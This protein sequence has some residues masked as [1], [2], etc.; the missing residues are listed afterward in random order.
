[1]M[2]RDFQQ[3][4]LFQ[5]AK[6]YFKNLMNYSLTKSFSFIKTWDSLSSEFA[7]EAV[8][9]PSLYRF[10]RARILNDPDFQ[11]YLIYVNNLIKHEK[12]RMEMGLTNSVI[13]KIL[14]IMLKKEDARCKE[15]SIFKGFGEEGDPAG[16]IGSIK[17]VKT[18]L[19][20]GKQPGLKKSPAVI[21]YPFPPKMQ[22]AN[23]LANPN[24][25]ATQF[26]PNMPNVPHM[27]GNQPITLAH[28]SM[29]FPPR[30]TPQPIYPSN[31]PGLSLTQTNPG[32]ILPSNLPT[33][34]IA[35]MNAPSLQKKAAGFPSIT[36]IHPTSVRGNLP[37]FHNLGAQ[38][39]SLGFIGRGNRFGNAGTLEGNKG[40]AIGKKKHQIERQTKPEEMV[41]KSKSSS[42]RRKASDSRRDRKSSLSSDS[43]SLSLSSISYSLDTKEEPKKKSKNTSPYILLQTASIYINFRE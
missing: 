26:R 33:S 21:N 20:T 41:K 35:Q 30:P 18:E 28:Q 14:F 23:I 36:Q 7:G 1:M 15:K 31:Q 43:H 12:G 16:K 38:F 13:F 5:K 3:E 19:T 25:P 6:S 29:S 34:N 27:R 40:Q 2:F 37:V 39:Q 22:P 42:K 17:K 9:F 24:I 4:Q 32:F 8:H 10:L 11:F